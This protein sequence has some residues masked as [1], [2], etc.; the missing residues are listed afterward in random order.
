LH[1]FEFSV[2]HANDVYRMLN[3]NT[4]SIIRSRDII[5]LNEAYHNWIEKNDGD[6]IANLKIQE[7]NYDEDKLRST[8]D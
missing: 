3:L 6:I 5:S 4:R 8:Q 7:I 1:V 2:H